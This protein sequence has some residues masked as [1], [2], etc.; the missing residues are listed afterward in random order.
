M[1]KEWLNDNQIDRDDGLRHD[2]WACMMWPRLKLLHELLSADRS[3][4][5]T[6]DDNEIAHARAILDEIFGQHNFIATCIRHKVYSPKN[7]AKHFPED[8]DYLLVYTKN[9]EK[10]RPNL[11][12]RTEAMEERY[13]NPDNDPRGP[14]KP[15]DLTARNPYS[16]GKYEVVGPTGKT[17][18]SG[19]IYW[20]QSKESFLQM[21][22]ENRI[23]WG[24]DG[25]NMPAQKRFLSEIKQGVTPQ[26]I[27]QYSEARHTQE[28]K[29]ELNSI[30][31][32]NSDNEAFVTPKPVALVSKIIQLACDTN[33][34]VLDSFAGSATTA[35]AVLAANTRD[36]GN[37]RFI[38]VEG[39]DYADTLT[40]ER[41]RRVINGYPFQGTQHEELLREKITFT[42]L[43]NA[44]S[45]MEKVQQIETL[46][47]PKYDRIAKT[48][49]D[50]ALIV[51]GE[52]N[53]QETAPGLG[54]EF[55][56]CTLGAPIE[57]EKI[58]SGEG[59]PTLEAIAGLL[60]HTATATTL[61]G[62]AIISKGDIADG[63]YQ[64]GE[65]GGRTYWLAYKP[66]L[67]WLKS[68]EAA[69]SLSMARAIAATQPGNHL[70]FAPAKFVS[71]E[72]LSRE[73]VN[74]DYAPLP[75]A[76]YRMVKA[77][78][79][80]CSN[81]CRDQRR[82]SQQQSGDKC[83]GQK[84]AH[85]Y[86]PC[87]CLEA[88]VRRRTKVHQGRLVKAGGV[89][90]AYFPLVDSQRDC[91]RFY[92]SET[93]SIL[94]RATSQ[95]VLLKDLPSLQNNT[96]DGP[97]KV[98]EKLKRRALAGRLANQQPLHFWYWL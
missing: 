15:S 17:F 30:M 53:V 32:Y 78:Q 18:N 68:G 75:F 25:S 70:V 77:W 93:L 40:A 22:S 85:G 62:N 48:V 26:T 80:S 65:H 31:S 90:Q 67:D 43:R 7:T 98:L 46:D 35:H 19:T 94:R 76:L 14:W 74:V 54:G 58:L 87:R 82:T 72:L 1:I 60:W 11:L 33:S 61:E 50:G 56:Y 81:W 66:D 9:A 8:H 41:V 36:G 83:S 69:L 96:S 27:W 42:K 73:K 47:G 49:R 95:T 23:W 59:L 5:I 13:T 86:I 39:E 92:T 2:K 57:M 63:L 71:R 97:D 44:N 64:L 4:W 45:L 6:L 55:T 52:R 28:A 24:E 34:L 89:S 88:N 29:Q 21:D 3:I 84:M 79:R 37:R 38:M 12:L 91:R 16:K 51:T 10:W 20:R